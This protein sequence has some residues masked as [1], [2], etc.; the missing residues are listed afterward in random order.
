M[1]HVITVE[2]RSLLVVDNARS[3]S[4]VLIR[5]ANEQIKCRV[6][7]ETP[8]KDMQKITNANDLCQKVAFLL[9]Y[10]EKNL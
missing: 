1:Q 10:F 9:V 2:G 7:E 8:C 6:S 3:L 5:V 4:E